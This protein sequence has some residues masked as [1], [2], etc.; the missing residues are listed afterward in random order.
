MIEIAPIEL[1]TFTAEEY[2]GGVIPQKAYV[3]A[4]LSK[5]GLEIPDDRLSGIRASEDNKLVGRFF[6]DEGYSPSTQLGQLTQLIVSEAS[7]V[8]SLRELLKMKKRQDNPM[9]QRVMESLGEVRSVKKQIAASIFGDQATHFTTRLADAFF[10][11]RNRETFPMPGKDRIG[12]MTERNR[13]LS[14][15]VEEIR[16]NYPLT[17]R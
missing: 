11:H 8:N 7:G 9:V 3:K 4:I 10:A 6:R 13:M 14:G 5:H 16:T 1:D 12:R 2:A 15:V 17:S